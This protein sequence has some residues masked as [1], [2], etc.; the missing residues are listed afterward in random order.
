MY[1]DNYSQG[2]TSGTI[3]TGSGLMITLLSTIGAKRFGEGLGIVN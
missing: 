3:G 2:S 1:A